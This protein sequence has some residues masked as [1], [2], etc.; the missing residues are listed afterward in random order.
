MRGSERE[1]ID[2]GLDDLPENIRKALEMRERH[3]YKTGAVLMDRNITISELVD[4]ML[5]KSKRENADTTYSSYK[6]RGKHIKEYFGNT[7]VRSIDVPMVENF[8]DELFLTCELQPRSVKDIKVFFGGVMNLAVEG[9][10]IFLNSAKQAKISKKL[11]REYAEEDSEDDEFFSYEESVLF[12]SRIEDHDLYE[13]YY[14]SLFFGLRREEALGL[15]WSAIDLKRKILK[16]Y[17]SI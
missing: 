6:Y 16:I 4:M 8:L 2:T 9:G 10:I 1:W 12:L 3:L 7:K 15:R 11:C 13:Y 17:R 14:V 5:E